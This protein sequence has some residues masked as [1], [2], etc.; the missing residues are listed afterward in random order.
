MHDFGQKIGFSAFERQIP[1][2]VRRGE[3]SARSLQSSPLPPLVVHF[4]AKARIE[5]KTEARDGLPVSRIKTEAEIQ[6]GQQN[7]TTTQFASKYG[8]NRFSWPRRVRVARNSNVIRTIIRLW[9]HRISCDIQ[10]RPPLKR[11]VRSEK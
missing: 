6:F 5:G 8:W 9:R 10:S 11:L 7:S 4:Q 3:A 1:P 2:L